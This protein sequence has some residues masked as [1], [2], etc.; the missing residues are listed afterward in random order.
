MCTVFLGSPR[1]ERAANSCRLSEAKRRIFVLT[2]RKAI[3]GDEFMND[4]RDRM[5]QVIAIYDSNR[6]K[7]RLLQNHFH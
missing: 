1:N 6:N 3:T 5:G 2:V 4:S 7:H